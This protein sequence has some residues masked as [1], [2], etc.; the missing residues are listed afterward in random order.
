[1]K[2]SP[3]SAI[4]RMAA[5]W[6]RAKGRDYGMPTVSLGMRQATR[7]LLLHGCSS[8]MVSSLIY[9]TDTSAFFRK[10]QTEIADMARVAAEDGVWPPKDLDPSDPLASEPHNQNVLAWWAFERAVEILAQRAGIEV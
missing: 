4:E 9:Y 10:H 3:D 1:M 6:L 2:L 8:G 7:E 5:K